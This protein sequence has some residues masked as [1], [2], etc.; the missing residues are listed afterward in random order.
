MLF[1]SPVVAGPYIFNAQALYDEMYDEVCAIPAK[2]AAD[3]RRH[4]IGMMTYPHIRGQMRDAALRYAARQGASLKAAMDLLEPLLPE[5]S[6][7][8]PWPSE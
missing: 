1:R 4:L 6:T 7:A 3:L 5:R 2:D 8:S